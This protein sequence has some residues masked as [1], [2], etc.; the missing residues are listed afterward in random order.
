MAVDGPTNFLQFQNGMEAS[1]FKLWLRGPVR[2]RA[3][4]KVTVDC[5]DA[6]NDCNDQ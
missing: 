5:P 6:W 2:P 3:R 4:P 1:D